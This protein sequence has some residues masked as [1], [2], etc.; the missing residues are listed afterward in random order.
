VGFEDSCTTVKSENVPRRQLYVVPSGGFA[1]A[2]VSGVVPTA[3]PV[4][5]D[6]GWL[7]IS[8]APM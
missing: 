2:I 6:R 7:V 3:P 4:T 8:I 5:T 1:T